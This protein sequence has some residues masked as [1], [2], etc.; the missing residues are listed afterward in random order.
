MFSGITQIAK[1]F[2]G[3]L[4]DAYGV[5]WGG[6]DIGLFPGSKEVMERLVSEGKTVGILSNSTQLVAKEKA[7]FQA[8]GLIE[9][10]HFHFLITSGEIARSLFLNEELPFKTT[11]KKFFVFGEPHPRFSSHAAIFQGTRFT[12]TSDIDKA[13][14]IHIAVPHLGGSDQTDPQLFCDNVQKLQRKDLPMVCLNPDRFAHEGKPP[15]R[16]VRQGSIAAMYE[17]LGGQVHYVGKPYKIAFSTAMDYF[18]PYGISCLEDIIMVGDNPDTDI[19][20][21]CHFGLSSALITQTGIMAD[22][23]SHQGLEKAIQELS[24]HPNF[25]VKKFVNDI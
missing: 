19:R 4:L 12:E 20:G 23:I 8:N 22:R 9:G 11:F 14:F 24:E 2:R 13:D 15:Q 17:S 3:I 21:A 25:F 5:F 7:K 1:N 10:K 16:V 18:R 6:N